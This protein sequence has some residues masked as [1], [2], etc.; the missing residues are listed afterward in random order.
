MWVAV[1]DHVRAAKGQKL[2]REVV[3]LMK[4]AVKAGYSDVPWGDEVGEQPAVVCWVG[5]CGCRAILAGKIGVEAAWKS[6]R[7]C[8]EA[9][10][11]AAGG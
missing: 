4:L 6:G 5:G 10:L 1:R 11:V 3:E 2:D 8:R 7:S 9:T